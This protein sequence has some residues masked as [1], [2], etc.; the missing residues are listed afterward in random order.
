MKIE[1]LGCSGSV[2]K[3]Y[4]TTS[5]LIN[6]SVLLDAGSAASIL[7]QDRLSKISDIL[8]THAHLDHIK[9]LPFI[10]DTVSTAG[11]S[12]TIW[13]STETIDILNENIFNG[14]VW[15]H[16][17]LLDYGKNNLSFKSVSNGWVEINDLK[18]LALPVDHIMGSVGYVV[19]EKDKV[20]MFSGDTS[21]MEGFFNHAK[22]Y[23][24]NLKAVFAEISYPDEMSDLARETCHMTPDEILK[25]LEFL[26]PLKTKLFV[27]HLKPYYMDLI[28]SKLPEGVECINSG[29]VF[30]F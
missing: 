4:P 16:F 26:N 8:I 15:P 25:A 13:A 29:E 5:I 27:Y 1:I 7:D 28:I 24:E 12:L 23:G 9:E 17:N 18:I 2:A 30:E 3:G 14:F 22:E 19:K 20:V 10:I 21:Y 11:N 6:K